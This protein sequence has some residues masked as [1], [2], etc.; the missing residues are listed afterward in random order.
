MDAEAFWAFSR[1]F[2]ARDGVAPSCITLQDVYGADVD[3]ILFTL[4]CASRG[5]RI[6]LSELEAVDAAVASWR[7]SVVQP[8][9]SARRALKPA[10]APPFHP[11]AAAALR[12][13]LLSAEL[14]AERLQQAAMQALAPVPGTAEPGQAAADNLACY[15]LQ[16]GIPPDAAP[17]AKLHQA[18]L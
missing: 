2:Y 16:A 5:C 13:R 4:W 18:F 8:I 7:V 9:R 1:E 3:V 14:E 10:P 17:I 6:E 15:A 11:G 12:E